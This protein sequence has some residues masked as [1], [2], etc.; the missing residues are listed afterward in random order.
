MLQTPCS[1]LS[2]ARRQLPSRA[3]SPRRSTPRRP[4]LAP[5]SRRRARLHLQLTRTSPSLSLR[6]HCHRLSLRARC[7]S[8]RE[9][10]SLAPAALTV[11]L[12]QGYRNRFL[13]SVDADN[14]EKAQQTHHSQ[15]AEKSPPPQSASTPTV[16]GVQLSRLFITGKPLQLKYLFHALRISYDARGPN[17]FAVMN[18]LASPIE[19]VHLH[20]EQLV[21][22]DTLIAGEQGR[23]QR[24]RDSSRTQGPSQ[25]Q[26]RGEGA[27]VQWQ[28]D[29]EAESEE[30]YI[31]GASEILPS[32]FIAKLIRATPARYH[33]SIWQRVYSMTVNGVSFS[34]FLAI[35]AQHPCSLCFIKDMRG[36]RFGGFASVPFISH[37]QAANA[38]Y[39]SGESWV[40]KV[41]ERSSEEKELEECEQQAE[42]AS[43]RSHSNNISLS[44]DSAEQALGSAAGEPNNKVTVFRWSGLND[45]FMFTGDDPSYI[46]MGG[47]DSFAWRLDSNFRF[48]KSGECSTFQSP[49]LAS[50][51]DF[52]AILF[53]AW[54]PI[55]GRW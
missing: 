49:L 20:S 40:F 44:I 10:L 9:A 22:V 52:E 42:R 1:T 55:R 27:E 4:S 50:A 35:S 25:S 21:A 17:S 18:P 36:A 47:G 8:E 14:L 7:S 54:V 16:A 3:N 19:S 53:E 12:R 32:Q 48:G 31:E 11:A 2:W 34:Q 24:E 39:G 33:L 43:L 51:K 45:Y 15:V 6:S 28:K 13:F 46:A 26:A 37:G 5:P 23:P 41:S 38:Y 30:V 29:R